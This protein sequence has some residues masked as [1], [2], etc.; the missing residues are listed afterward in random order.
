MIKSWRRGLNCLGLRQVTYSKAQHFHGLVFRKPRQI[1]QDLTSSDAKCST[2]ELQK[3]FFIP[4][5]NEGHNNDNNEF[6]KCESEVKH[7]ELD[8]DCIISDFEELPS[9]DL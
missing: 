8:R 6:D 5:D 9:P 1:I 3:S 7:H 2:E 4:Q